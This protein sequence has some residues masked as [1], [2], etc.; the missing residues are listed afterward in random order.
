MVVERGV[1]KTRVLEVHHLNKRVV[2]V[3][4]VEHLLK[5]QR[6]H[7]LAVGALLAVCSFAQDAIPYAEYGRNDADATPLYNK[8][9]PCLRALFVKG[10]KHIR[11][12]H[13]ALLDGAEHRS[14]VQYGA[15]DKLRY[16][17]AFCEYLY[18]HRARV[19]RFCLVKV[20]KKK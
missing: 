3:E 9:M 18:A 16:F 8:Y 14:G 2:E 13:P 6:E 5:E 11:L 4:H 10:H 19:E 20:T 15:V 17:L 12:S 7:L 1:C